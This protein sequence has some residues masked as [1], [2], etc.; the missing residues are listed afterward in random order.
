MA[1]KPAQPVQSTTVKTNAAVINGP[2][3]GKPD[4][5]RPPQKPRRI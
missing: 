4:G 1:K 2:R 3:K 5:G